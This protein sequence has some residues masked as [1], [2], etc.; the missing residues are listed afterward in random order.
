MQNLSSKSGLPTVSAAPRVTFHLGSLRIRRTFAT[1]W[2]V[3]V[4][5]NQKADRQPVSRPIESFK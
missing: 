5:S 1:S 3:G 2:P 4:L